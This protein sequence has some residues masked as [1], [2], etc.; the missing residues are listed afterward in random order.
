MAQK[1][2]NVLSV[3]K[4]AKTEAISGNMLKISISQIHFCTVVSFARKL[5]MPEIICMYM[6][7]H[8]IET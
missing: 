7:Q 3:E 1:L 8:T 4:L 6:S 2:T 5:L